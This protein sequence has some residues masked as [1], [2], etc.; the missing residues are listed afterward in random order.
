MK[1]YRV[2]AALIAFTVTFAFFLTTGIFQNVGRSPHIQLVNPS[3]SQQEMMDMLARAGKD[4]LIFDYHLDDQ[5]QHME[6]WVEIYHYGELIARRG[7]ISV[8][9]GEQPIGSGQFML[10]RDQGLHFSAPQDFQWTFFTEFGTFQDERW[11]REEDTPL[12]RGWGPITAPQPIQDGQ[13]IVLHATR[14]AA[15]SLR[16]FYDLQMYL[17]PE[18]REDITY[19]HLIVARFSSFLEV[20]YRYLPDTSGG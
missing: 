11:S 8:R 15:G 7:G 13:E 3:R 19:L 18:N 16:T 5:I 17:E 9:A 6:V 12:S 2:I 14:F 20:K 4:F 1:Q 10:L